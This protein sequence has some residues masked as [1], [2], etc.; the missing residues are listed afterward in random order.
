MRGGAGVCLGE[1]DGSI[2][3]VFEDGYANGEDDE[4][5]GDSE[6]VDRADDD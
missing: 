5:E 2:A 3:E 1:E 6:E 4:G